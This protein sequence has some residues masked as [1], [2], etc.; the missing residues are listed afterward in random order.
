MGFLSRLFNVPTEKPAKEFNDPVF[1]IGLMRSGTTLLMHSLS[2]HPQLLKVGFELNTMWRE[3]GGLKGEKNTCPRLTEEDFKQ[4]YLKNVVHYFSDYIADSK[5]ILRHLSRFD[6]RRVHGSGGIFYDWNHVIPLNK[7]P[8]LSN[9]VRYLSRL[10]PRAKFIVLVRPIE[11]Q[12]ASMKKHFQ[13]ADVQKGKK[14]FLPDEDGSCWSRLDESI[15]SAGIKTANEDFSSI[16]KS[17]VSLNYVMLKDLEEVENLSLIVDYNDLVKDQAATLTKIFKFLDLRK[18]HKSKEVKI[19]AKKRKIHN[20]TT[21]GDPLT[22]WK[23]N[24]SDTEKQLLKKVVSANKEK[25]EYIQQR[26]KDAK[27]KG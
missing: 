15:D 4:R 18:E 5:S 2:E 23:K 8:H 7:S 27:S 10:F 12:T 26:L 1:L 13:N 22:K 14:F 6:Q 25:V 17:W 3:V 21:K 24:L 16:V 11:S 19:V 20:T 9:K